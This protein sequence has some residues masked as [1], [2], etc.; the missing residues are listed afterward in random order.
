MKLND[1]FARL[2]FVT[3]T[4]II[5]PTL[6][7]LLFVLAV[8]GGFLIYMMGLFL[9]GGWQLLSALCHFLFRG[10]RFRGWYLMASLTYLGV[11]GVGSYILEQTSLGASTLF[12]LGIV[13][14]GVIP[15]I[16]GAWYYKLTF[17]GEEYPSPI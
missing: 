10:D 4:L 7:S 16:A 11:L 3:Q 12:Y 5:F 2:D 9:L 8:P 15:G 1:F 13:F 14:F 6:A 17:D